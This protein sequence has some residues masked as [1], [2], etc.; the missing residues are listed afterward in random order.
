MLVDINESIIGEGYVTEESTVEQAIKCL[1]DSVDLCKLFCL[2]N[3]INTPQQH[4]ALFNLLRLANVF[5]S[6]PSLS[7]LT[8]S[9]EIYDKLNKTPIKHT[10]DWFIKETQEKFFIRKGNERWD[11]KD[12]DWLINNKESVILDSKIEYVRPYLA[13]KL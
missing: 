4:E 11:V 3:F 13:D 10:L 8:S 6:D 9:H 5:D 2:G 1:D 7:S 12:P